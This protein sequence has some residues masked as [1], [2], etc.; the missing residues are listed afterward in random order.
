MAKTLAQSVPVE[1]VPE[2]EDK[3]RSATIREASNGYIVE[4]RC[5]NPYM[6][7]TLVFPNLKKV[8]ASLIGFF[9]AETGE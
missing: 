1:L 8:L 9:K 4:I 2:G 5:D 6:N 3:R 7:T